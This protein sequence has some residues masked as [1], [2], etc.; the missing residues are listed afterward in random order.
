MRSLRLA[1]R[2]PMEILR[3][4]GSWSVNDARRERTARNAKYERSDRGG[5]AAS[6]KVRPA[7]RARSR[8]GSG[9][10]PGLHRTGAYEE[11][12][13]PEGYQPAGLDVHDDAQPV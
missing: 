2:I 3:P 8:R 4:S 6:G 9:S 7:P 11:R 12:P 1:R 13:L 10:G 5:T